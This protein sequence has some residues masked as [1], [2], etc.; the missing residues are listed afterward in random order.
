[1]YRP[2]NWLKT[3]RDIIAEAPLRAKA[4]EENVV[5]LYEAG[6]DAMLEALK[7]EAVEC[8]ANKEPFDF[9]GMTVHNSKSRRGWLVFIPEEEQ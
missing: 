3:K 5:D 6:A 4:N 9:C 2:K 1:M 7:E 8:P